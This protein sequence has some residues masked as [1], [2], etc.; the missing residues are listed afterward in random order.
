[1]SLGATVAA[2]YGDLIARMWVSGSRRGLG[3][4]FLCSLVWPI[5]CLLPQESSWSLRVGATDPRVWR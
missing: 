4:T 5:G 3:M 2:R 1:V